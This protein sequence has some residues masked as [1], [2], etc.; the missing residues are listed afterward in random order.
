MFYSN[1]K[2]FT[3]TSH[4][5]LIFSDIFA[6]SKSK[7]MLL[8]DIITDFFDLDFWLRLPS[9]FVFV[10]YFVLTTLL[11]Y[12]HYVFIS[13]HLLESWVKIVVSYRF[14][15]IFLFCCLLTIQIFPFHVTLCLFI[16]PRAVLVCTTEASYIYN[17]IPFRF[18]IHLAVSQ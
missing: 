9:F 10:S 3:K 6:S 1:Q 7:I 14:F 15:G 8:L 17:D 12:G 16:F 4:S 2:Y 5:V 11:A 13:K 18:I